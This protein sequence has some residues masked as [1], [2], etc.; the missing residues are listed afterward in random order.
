MSHTKLIKC[1]ISLCGHHIG[2]KRETDIGDGKT[3]AL[4]ML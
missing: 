3:I 1:S 2:F 4:R